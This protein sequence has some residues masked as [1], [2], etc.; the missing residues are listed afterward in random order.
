[1]LLR[2]FPR[3]VRRNEHLFQVDAGLPAAEQRDA[4]LVA[5]V[6]AAIAVDGNT[7]RQART[8]LPDGAEFGNKE[9]LL[10][11]AVATAVDG[12]GIAD[13]VRAAL[14]HEP[15]HAHVDAVADEGTAGGIGGGRQSILRQ[16]DADAADA[17]GLDAVAVLEIAVG[18]VGRCGGQYG[19]QACRRR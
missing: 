18:G 13:D 16:R 7:G 8:D 6:H 1:V 14:G 15:A 5:G 10:A 17:L 12:C 9:M 19:Q 11:V 2:D 4:A 3:E